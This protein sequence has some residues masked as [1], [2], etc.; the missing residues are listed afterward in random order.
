[1]KELP[2]FNRPGYKLEKKGASSLDDAE[3]MSIILGYGS[4]EES[5]LELSNRLLN[6]HNLHRFENLGFRELISD[7]GNSKLNK[8][9]FI[10]V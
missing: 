4:K 10:L 3:L 9:N 7:V 6:K 8:E 1:M 2:W 5:V